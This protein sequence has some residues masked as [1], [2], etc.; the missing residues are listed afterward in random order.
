MSRHKLADLLLVHAIEVSGG[1]EFAE[2]FLN[3][4]RSRLRCPKDR[5]HERDPWV[6]ENVLRY[7]ITI[8]RRIVKLRPEFSG[9]LGLVKSCEQAVNY[10]ENSRAGK[11]HTADWTINDGRLRW[12]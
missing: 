9:A 1:D 6:F 11:N 7:V 12:S 10:A 3:D 4:M 2:G 5:K 8:G